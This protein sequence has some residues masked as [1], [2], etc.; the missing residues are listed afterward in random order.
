[1]SKY[2]FAFS[3]LTLLLTETTTS[4]WNYPVGFD[5]L[6]PFVKFAL[7]FEWFF[8]AFASWKVFIYWTIIFAYSSDGFICSGQNLVLIHWSEFTF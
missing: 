4:R 6:F 1:M 7:T 8:L 2:V 3:L 5:I